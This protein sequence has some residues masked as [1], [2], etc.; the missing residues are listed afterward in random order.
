MTSTYHYDRAY[1]AL[2]AK[3]EL[4]YGAYPSDKQSKWIAGQVAMR[5]QHAHNKELLARAYQI[6]DHNGY[7][8]PWAEK[9]E[10]DQTELDHLIQWTQTELDAANEIPF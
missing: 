3:G 8:A 7:W 5:E 10:E 1:V 2:C 9:V 6:F 4:D